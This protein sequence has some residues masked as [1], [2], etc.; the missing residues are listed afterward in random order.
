MTPDAGLAQT[1]VDWD[2]GVRRERWREAS[3]FFL[4]VLA[5]IAFF[6]AR[7][8]P[9]DSGDRGSVIAM[10]VVLLAYVAWAAAWF[11]TGLLAGR[12]DRYRALYA[13]SEHL[14]PGPG[15]RTRTDGLARGQAPNRWAPVRAVGPARDRGPGGGRP[16]GLH[17]R[18]GAAA[19]PPGRSRTPVARRPAGARA[20]PG[21]RASAPPGTGQLEGRRRPGP[22]WP[23]R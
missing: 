8:D 11:V 12:T 13:L 17:D 15:L 14:D 6:V 5:L 3:T 19:V 23:W 9:S 2:A 1:R 20:G 7:Y 10:G 21:A 18:D 16:R 4:I 22:G